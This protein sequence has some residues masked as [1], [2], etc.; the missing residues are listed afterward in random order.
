MCAIPVSTYLFGKMPPHIVLMRRIYHR[1]PQRCD[2][3][4]DIDRPFSD[5]IG[6]IVGMHDT[7]VTSRKDE[8]LVKL[9]T[10]V[11]IA[12]SKT[13]ME[14]VDRFANLQETVTETADFRISLHE[15]LLTP[16]QRLPV[17]ENIFLLRV[18]DTGQGCECFALKEN[19]KGSMD[20]MD[21]KNI[22]KGACD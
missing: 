12:E 6:C 8:D 19:A 22:I 5:V 20:A 18:S 17:S 4:F 7:H 14:P 1:F 11:E 3:T 10:V 16:A 9:R 15:T 21:L 2:L 13:K